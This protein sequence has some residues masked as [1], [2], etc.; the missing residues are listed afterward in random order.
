[1]PLAPLPCSKGDWQPV[2]LPVQ[3]RTRGKGICQEQGVRV[4][5]QI[6]S[7]RYRHCVSLLFRP[8]HFMSSPKLLLIAGSIIRLHI[9]DTFPEFLD[10]YF[11]ST[12]YCVGW[13]CK[14]IALSLAREMSFIGRGSRRNDNHKSDQPT[15]SQLG[16]YLLCE[17]IFSSLFWAV[18]FHFRL[19]QGNEVHLDWVTGH[20]QWVMK[21]IAFAAEERS[22]WVQVSPQRPAWLPPQMSAEICKTHLL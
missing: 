11:V 21:D 3:W 6:S 20:F 22:R 8:S 15:L 13:L 16:L 17:I 14:S 12:W 10:K 1:M 4:Q 19:S 7:G 5:L 2:A 18:S 9:P